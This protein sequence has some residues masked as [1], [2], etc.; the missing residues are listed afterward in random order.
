MTGLRNRIFSYRH[1]D[2]IAGIIFFSTFIP[3]WILI[4]TN[5]YETVGAYLLIPSFLIII[6]GWLMPKD[7]L[8]NKITE[9]SSE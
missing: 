9:R 3:G 7:E 2:T 6:I 8:T 4:N 5:G 1:T